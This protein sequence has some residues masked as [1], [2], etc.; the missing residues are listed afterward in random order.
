MVN[1]RASW[2]RNPRWQE[3]G[4]ANN[5]FD[6]RDALCGSYFDPSDTA[7]LVSPVLADVRTLTLRQPVSIQLGLKHNL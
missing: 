3:F 6:N 2:R 1:L 4:T 5:V 7:G